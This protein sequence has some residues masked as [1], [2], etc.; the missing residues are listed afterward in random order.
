MNKQ[1]VNLKAAKSLGLKAFIRKQ[2]F[3]IEDVVVCDNFGN[4][5]VF[6]IFRNS[7]DLIAVVKMLGEKYGV[8]I[9]GDGEKWYIFDFE[10]GWCADDWY[11]TYEEAVAAAI[12]EV[13][14]E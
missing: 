11:S 4:E 9:I 13:N 6:N 14:G 2:A 10:N 8:N 1:E 12:C 5:R 3:S 7:S